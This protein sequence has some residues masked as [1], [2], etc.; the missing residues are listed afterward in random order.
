MPLKKGWNKHKIRETPT[1]EAPRKAM[2][3]IKDI[4]TILAAGRK[5][6]TTTIAGLV[7]GAALFVSQQGEEID[8]ADWKAWLP[9]L[10][11]FA[12]GY[13]AKNAHN[14]GANGGESSVN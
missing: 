2:K 9:A 3:V 10:A 5:N 12:L 11:I 14:S 8:W 13:V 7:A 6:W 1:I 4:S